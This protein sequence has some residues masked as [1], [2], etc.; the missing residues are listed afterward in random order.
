MTYFV[1][2]ATGFIGRFLIERLLERDGEINVLVR[3]GSRD[4]LDALI[5]RWG[6]GGRIRPVVGDLSEARLGVSRR[7]GRAA[8]RLGRALLPPRGH[9]RH[10]RRRR[11]QRAAQRRGHQ[12]RRRPGQHAAGRAPAPRLL[13]GGG[14]Q[15]RRLLPRGHVRRGPGAALALPP[16]QVRV[17]EDRPQP[18]HGAVAGL[19]A[20]RR[21]RA[22]Q[23][24]RDGQDRR[25][26]LLLHGHQEAAAPAA[27]VGAAGRPGARPHQHRPGRLR[28]RR[29]RPH[30][31]PAR[32][33]RPGLPPHRPEGDPL[34]RGD[35]HLRQ[36]GAT[37]P[38]SRC[39]STS[40]SSTRCRRASSRWRCRSRP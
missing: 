25:A 30:R 14:R 34:R 13:G 18:E 36:G 5:E 16:D 38:S 21:R 3:E 19:P 40:G 8:D 29:A 1:T 24:R 15:L 22:Q 27:R 33:R 4:R 10:D 35:Q 20:G 23:D 6:G 11:D 28:R 37:R 39:G 7:G 17:G 2:G 31:P 12:A 9:L 26:V 32:P